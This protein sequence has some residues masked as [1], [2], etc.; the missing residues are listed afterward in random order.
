[1]P[2]SKPSDPAAAAAGG[3]DLSIACA[4]VG[5]VMMAL[6]AELFH[7]GAGLILGGLALLVVGIVGAPRKR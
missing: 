5:I 3:R 1:M 7:Q 2:E 6:G 4:V